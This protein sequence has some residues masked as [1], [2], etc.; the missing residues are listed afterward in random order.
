MNTTYSI[1][2]NTTVMKIGGKLFLLIFYQNTTNGGY[3]ANREEV[4]DFNTPNK[5]SIIGKIDESFYYNGKYEFLYE[6]PGYRGYN[7]WRQKIHPSDT[8]ENTTSDDYQYEAVK[9]AWTVGFGGGL[10]FNK[11]ASTLTAF[12]C[13]FDDDGWWYPIGVINKYAYPNNMPT[14][15][16]GNILSPEVK[17][18]IRVPPTLGL[19]PVLTVCRKAKA[20]GIMP[21]VAVILLCFSRGVPTK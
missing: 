14:I 15:P 2:G 21:Q 3:F 11:K 10:G 16:Q 4:L 9:L 13:S 7:T 18:W 8:N 1:L 17:L 19:D 12:D 20:F 6:V 5:F